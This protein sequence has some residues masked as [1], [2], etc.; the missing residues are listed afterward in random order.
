[1]INNEI[2]KKIP[3][4]IF[5]VPYRNRENQKTHFSVYIKYIMEDYN[6]EDYEIY[7]VHQNDNRSFNRGGIK[8]VGF[9]IIKEKYPENYKNITFVFNDI[10]TIPYKK[11]ILNYETESNVVK[12]FYGFEFSLGGIFS[13]K[14]NDFERINGFPNFWGYGY[15]DNVLNSRVLSNNIKLDRTNFY[16]INSS[17]IIQFKDKNFIK[18][19][20]SKEVINLK[21]KRIFDNLSNIKNLTYEIIPNTEDNS[22]ICKN[23]YLINVTWFD[24]FIAY[25]NQNFVNFDTSKE[26]KVHVNSINRIVPRQFLMKLN[27]K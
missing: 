10:D 24:T 14:G 18:Q 27:N 23:Q 5:I 12:H 6:L 4:I 8:N 22:I 7:Y 1:M 17:E 26:N 11:N 13:I 25:I 19:Y 21:N 20:N 15:E 9:L 2:N 16:K 3:K